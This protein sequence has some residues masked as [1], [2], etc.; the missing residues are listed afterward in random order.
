MN[1]SDALKLFDDSPSKAAAAIGCTPQAVSQWPEILTPRIA[2]RVTAALVRL[3]TKKPKY[4]RDSSN[5]KV[6][7]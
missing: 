3:G 2:D 1:K 5:D 7:L 4:R 6:S